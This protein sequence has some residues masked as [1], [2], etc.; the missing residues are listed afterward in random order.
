MTKEDALLYFPVEEEDDIDDLFE[1]LL[2]EQKQFLTTQMPI[3]KV[4][5]SRL[6]R[7]ENIEKAYVFFGGKIEENLNSSTEILPYNSD[8]IEDIYFIFQKNK[9]TLKLALFNSK[10]FSEIKNIV[11]LLFD[12]YSNLAEKF[13]AI[14]LNELNRPIISKEPDE[15]ELIDEIKSLKAKGIVNFSE[16]SQL[17]YDNILIQEAIRL[18]LWLNLEKNV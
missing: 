1:Q 2:F 4:F 14:E 9:N 15:M 6:N 12:N 18:S 10:S 11:T 13:P 8:L 5:N 7:I 3:S 17:E 16:L